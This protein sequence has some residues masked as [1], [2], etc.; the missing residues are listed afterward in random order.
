MGVVSIDVR[1][2]YLDMKNMQEVT[3]DESKKLQLKILINV[4]K[5][6]DEHNINYSLAYGTLIGAVRHKGF[7]PWDDDIDIIMMRDDYER[8]V[9]TYN[10]DSFDLVDGDHQLNH[11]HVRI[12]D[13]NTRIVSLE[14][15]R[16]KY[17]KS[18]VW[19]DVFPID[20]VPDDKEE[21]QR[22]M[23]RIY[24]LC[25]LQLIAEVGGKD[26]KFPHKVLFNALQF[27]LKPL[28]VL[29]VNKAKKEM[30]KYNHSESNTVANISL[31]YLH[32][33]SF[34]IEYMKQFIKIE[35]EGHL[36]NSI[37]NYDG[38]L[39]GIYGDYMTPPPINKQAPRHKYV[40]YWR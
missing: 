9:T 36:F 4:A 39:K 6:C 28:G 16:D 33:P 8:F 7:I 40:A 18:G 38:Y 15:G 20:K 12:A 5:F 21:Y 30:V 2:K 31:W 13:K 32:Y 17:Y 10:D 22:F 14:G 26:R 27:F 37:S 29:F 19:I 3:P 1:I 23:K 34:S 11:L 24:I 35:F 25:K